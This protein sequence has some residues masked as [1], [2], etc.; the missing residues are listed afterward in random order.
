MNLFKTQSY[1]MDS[2]GLG[3]STWP[4]LQ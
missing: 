2:E 1:W 4:L 3:Y